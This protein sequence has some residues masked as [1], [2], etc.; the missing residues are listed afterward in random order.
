[1]LE[2]EADA[3]LAVDLACEM[4]PHWIVTSNGSEIMS[5]RSFCRWPIRA[6]MVLDPCDHTHVAY[7]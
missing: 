1:V 5:T 7:V 4:S 3:S 6:G 2:S